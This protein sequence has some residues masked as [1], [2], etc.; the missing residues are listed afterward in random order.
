MPEPATRRMLLGS[1]LPVAVVLAATGP[2]ATVAVLRQ[3]G[4]EAS[5]VAWLG[6]IAYLSIAAAVPVTIITG[7]LAHRQVSIFSIGICRSLGIP[8]IIAGMLMAG[9]TG[10]ALALAGLAVLNSVG[11]FI[12]GHGSAWLLDAAPGPSGAAVLAWRNALI[13]AGGAVGGIAVGWLADRFGADH[14]TWL[15]PVVLGLGL[16]GAMTE[17]AM[18]AKVGDGQR[19]GAGP[20]AQWSELRHCLVDARLWSGIRR[21]LPTSGP[22]ALIAPLA[23]WFLSDLLGSI[24]LAGLVTAI[25]TLTGLVLMWLG[26]AWF[27]RHD[28]DRVLAGALALAAAAN[29]AL[30]LPWTWMGLRALP[31]AA[32]A[33]LVSLLLSG[34]A[35]LGPAQIRNQWASLDPDHASMSAALWATITG[36]SALVVAILAAVALPWATQLAIGVQGFGLTWHGYGPLLLTAALIQGAAAAV[37]WRRRQPPGLAAAHPESVER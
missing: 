19:G 27:A 21:D 6:V 9:Q 10:L 33:A 25:S 7:H 5:Q 14:G 12:G 28:R 37:I 1:V 15:W 23:V 4:A 22:L 20:R 35:L 29:L 17:L 11:I 13:V 16:A 24:A 3:V 31:A 32:A 2:V 34:S 18:L 26:S 36:A 30:A 8:L